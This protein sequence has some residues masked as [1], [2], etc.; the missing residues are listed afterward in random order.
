MII[1]R[2]RLVRAMGIY[3]QSAFFILLIVVLSYVPVAAA[4][5]RGSPI[6]KSLAIDDINIALSRA[7]AVHPKLFWN[8]D[9]N[10]V[11]ARKNALITA[12]PDQARTMDVYLILSELVGMLGDGHVSVGRPRVGSGDALDAYTK[13]GGFLLYV[14]GR[15]T[16]AGLRVVQS[17]AHGVAV[18]DVLTTI[19]GQDAIGLFDRAIILQ[20][21][22][23]AFKRY[24]AMRAFPEA[25]WDLNI[26]APYRLEGIFSGKRGRV[27]V[28]AKTSLPM[29]AQHDK[30]DVG[31]SSKELS[32][33][34]VL[35][36]F[37]RMTGDPPRFRE[38]LRKIFIDIRAEKPPGI[39]VDLRNNGGGNSGLGDDLLDYLN[40]KPY[41]PF[42]RETFKASPE[43]REFF[44]KRF[45]DGYETTALRQM[46]DGDRHTWNIPVHPPAPNALRFNGPITF[47]IGPGTFSS[48]N[49]LAN[50]VGDYHLATMIGRDTAEIPNNYGMPCPILL[51]NS[52]IELE[53]P[54]TYFVRANGDE[55]DR[56]DVHPDINVVTS[57][58][59]EGAGDPDIHEAQK[60]IARHSF[61]DMP[62]A[63]VKLNASRNGSVTESMVRALTIGVVFGLTRFGIRK[64]AT[65]PWNGAWLATGLTFTIL[66]A[67]ALLARSVIRYS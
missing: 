10:L 48:A 27:V 14:A 32:D 65:A 5:H 64:Y 9:R 3:L 49:I 28:D 52:R 62:I 6:P 30:S 45:P 15:P 39:I 43:C 51:P 11:L 56:S 23:P 55:S 33:G 7:E 19:N 53:V 22:E 13:S 17:F 41:R 47:L 12:L 2:D 20:G 50:S 37:D 60:W 63:P 1:L 58:A 8:V 38:A 24:V 36:R 26:E 40:D 4:D 46:R 42:A 21:G 59:K 29:L 61:R 25:L 18:G 35:I 66:A 44:E 31:I 34:S 54:S 67:I 16:S 57:E